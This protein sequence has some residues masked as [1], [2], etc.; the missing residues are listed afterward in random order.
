MSVRDSILKIIQDSQQLPDTRKFSEVETAQFILKGDQ[1]SRI[2]QCENNIELFSL[3]YFPYYHTFEMPEFHKEMY[4]D[5]LFSDIDGAIWEMF[6]ESAKTS[7]A[8]ISIIHAIV[9]KKTNF[10]IWVSYDEKKAASNLFDVAVQLQTNERLIGDFGQLFYDEL[11][12]DEKDDPNAPRRRS[13]KKSIKEFITTTDIKV[14]AFSTGMSIRGE[15]YGQYRPDRIYLDD[16]ETMKTMVSEARTEQVKNFIDEMLSGAAGYANY[17]VLCNKISNNGSIVYLE[18]RLQEDK[19]WRVRNVPIILEDGKFAWPDKYVLTDKEAEEKNKDQ[20]NKF[21]KRVS[22]ETLKRRNG[23]TNFNREFMNQPLTEDE[24]EIKLLWLQKRFT[25]EMIAGKYRNRYI[26][27]DVAD[28][29]SRHKSDPDYTAITVVDV[30]GE[31]NW[32]VQYVSRGRYN[33]PEL[34]TRIFWL[35]ETYK[36]IKIGIEK[37]SLEDQIM[38]YIRT[39]SEETKIFPVIKELEHGGTRKEDRIRGAIQGPL[40]SGKIFFKDKAIDDTDKLI[41]ELYDF[42][43]AKKDDLSDALA[44]IKQIASKPFYGNDKT[45]MPLLHQEFF[46][47]KKMQH[48]K[49]RTAVSKIRSL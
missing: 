1:A 44:Y 22:I 4:K 9:Y 16:I 47:N 17:L 28:S 15:V 36:P 30:D 20:V 40:E 37:K 3:Y 8:K 26:T 10:T 35:W 49:M 14:K 7:L 43:R 23:A 27:I 5:L 25:D 11:L 12:E 2:A 38:P 29:K 13:K 45:M 41:A 18:E 34:I 32:Y 31:G 6:R 19:R 21:F 24:R 39:K 42:P 48:R 33:A 46:A